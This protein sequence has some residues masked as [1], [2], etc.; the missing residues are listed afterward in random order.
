MLNRDFSMM[1]TIISRN[2]ELISI[3]III[4]GG[5]RAQLS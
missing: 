1:I 3:L 4:I 2:N 5:I